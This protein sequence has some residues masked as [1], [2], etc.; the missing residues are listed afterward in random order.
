MKKVFAALISV[1][2]PF[3]ILCCSNPSS[4]SGTNVSQGTSAPEENPNS[5]SSGGAANS[6]PVSSFTGPYTSPTNGIVTYYD[7]TYGGGEAFFVPEIEEGWYGCAVYSNRIEKIPAN[8]AIEMTA[9]GKTIKLLVT[10]YCPID[11]SYKTPEGERL[12]DVGFFDLQRPAFAALFD[13]L[14]KGFEPVTFRTIPY[15]TAR[16]IKIQVKNGSGPWC[17]IFMPYNM[18]YPLKKVEVSLDGVNF[19]DASLVSISNQFKFL[20]ENNETVKCDGQSLTYFRL[21]DIYGQVVTSSAALESLY[22]SGNKTYDL[23][24]NFNY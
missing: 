3:F 22:T 10:D 13:D 23:G 4:S 9:N 12:M 14:Q 5:G 6:G 21:T 15:S 20:P 2:L 16:N 11:S 8:S 18:R 7:N 17:L 19:F 24:V 1:V